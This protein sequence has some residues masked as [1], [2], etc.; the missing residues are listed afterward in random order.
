MSDK[1]LPVSRKSSNAAVSL[2]RVDKLMKLSNKLVLEGKRA[3]EL[4]VD[5][6]WMTRLW[7]WADEND[8]DE[9]TLPRQ[10]EELLVLQ[11]LHLWKNFLTTLPPEIGQ[12]SQLQDLKLWGNFLTTLPPEIGQLSQLQELH[13]W[14]NFL[15]TLPPEIGQLSQLKW[16]NLYSNNL[17]TLP[18][19]IGQLSQLKWLIINDDKRHLL[20]TVL[21]EKESL[22]IIDSFI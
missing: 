22:T 9:Y 10:R 16:L 21:L 14:K 12:L 20:P 5:E 3:R 4:A 8:I 18:P 11:G 17:T 2:K 7:A 6:S 13:L 19:E 15:T 1:N